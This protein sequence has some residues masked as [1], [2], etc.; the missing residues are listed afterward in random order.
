MDSMNAG[1]AGTLPVSSSGDR[2]NSWKEIAAYLKREVR[3]LHRWEI[4]EG[5]P[6]HRHLHKKRGSVYAYRSELEAWWNER[7]VHLDE[8]ERAAP[9]GWDWRKTVLAG[10]L[11]LV[12]LGGSGYLLQQRARIHARLRNGRIMLA[13]LPFEDLSGDSQQEYFSDGLTEEM[14]ALLGNLNPRQMAV[15]ARS[16]SM[17]Y[18]HTNK[19]A[20]QIGRELGVDYLLEGSVRRDGG[21]VRVTAELIQLSDETHLWA[22]SYE[23]DQYDILALQS[24]VAR[25]IAREIQVKLTSTEQTRLAGARATEPEAHEAYLKGLYFWNKYTEEGMRESMRYFQQAIQKDRRYAEAYTGLSACYEILG[26]FSALPPDEAYPQA[27][28]ASSKALEIDDTLS[29]AHTQ[30]GYAVMFYDHDWSRAEGEFERALELNP[31]SANGHRGLAQYFLSSGRADEALAEIRRAR[32]LDPV[33]LNINFDQ[34]WYLYFA[35]KPDEA[36]VQ[37]RKTLEMDP[38]FLVAHYAMAGAY[39]EKGEFDQAIAEY[40]FTIA[41]SRD[42]TS[43]LG[44]LGH[45]YAVAG[46]TEEARQVLIRM[47]EVSTHRYLSPYHTALVYAGLG[48]KDEAF[49]WLEKAYKDHFWM[50]AFLKVDPRLDGLRSDPHFQDLLRRVGLTP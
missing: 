5:L 8:P 38:N 17:R 7:R 42:S 25:A 15:I 23:R 39:E 48:E 36:I 3:T 45:A 11:L 34:G 27:K 33:S 41:Q 31:S 1:P 19:G 47:K 46:R 6:I 21:R 37:L 16:S 12:V 4:E 9:R 32:D 35:R 22:H 10:T 40:E 29:E 43:R 44:S 26:N 18:K 49:A 50:L 20:G 24:E 30:L 2:L 13:V 28:A 14:I